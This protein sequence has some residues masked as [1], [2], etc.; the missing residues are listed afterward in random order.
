MEQSPRTDPTYAAAQ[1]RD[2]IAA[3]NRRPPLPKPK[4]TEHIWVAKLPAGLPVDMHVL[5]VEA[6]DMFGNVDLGIRIIEVE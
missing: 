6:T 2:V 3:G 5:E 1:Q 4:V